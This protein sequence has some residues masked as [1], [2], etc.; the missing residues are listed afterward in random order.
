MEVQPIKRKKDNRLLYVIIAAA[1]VVLVIILVL[2][3]SKPKLSYEDYVELG[4]KYMSSMGYNKAIE[5]YSMA[6][7][8]NP[9][10]TEAVLGLAD[11]YCSKGDPQKALEVLN[12]ADASNAAVSEKINTITAEFI[13]AADDTPSD[14]E[15]PAQDVEMS[16]VP[17]I[18]GQS[19]SAAVAACEAVG[20]SY[21]I[22]YSDEGGT[23]TGAVISQSVT[24]GASVPTGSVLGFTVYDGSQAA[25]T[26]VAEV[27]E[28]VADGDNASENNTPEQT[29]AAQAVS[30]A[31]P[32]KP[33]TKPKTD[34]PVQTSASSSKKPEAKTVTIK[35]K[36]LSL[37]A[38][39]VDLS[40]TELT[41]YDLTGIA[42]FTS[43]KKL[44]ISGNLLSDLTPLKKLTGLTELDVSD[45]NIKDLSALG[46]LKKLS[47]LNIG[48]NQISSLDGITGLTGLTVLKASNNSI[49]SISAASEL[50][51]LSELDL[52]CNSITD[53][54][55]LTGLTKLTNLNL[56]ENNIDSISGLSGLKK[57]KKLNIW[58]ND[59]SSSDAEVKELKEALPKCQISC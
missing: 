56:S 45:N 42:K 9:D 48:H 8:L 33:S 5:N 25:E 14:E 21:E 59:V 24:A 11:A 19:E 34:K 16:V 44:D 39:S 58:G 35:G 50:T 1:A 7:E 4:N 28:E 15:A 36:K 49:E 38:T 3:L 29:Q 41:D 13:T 51:A 46:S 52:S 23:E 40:N 30:P 22:T 37:D 31:S 47:V 27:G 20:L 17:D 6:V 57:L 10:G 55:S 54:S 2:A 43:L 26:G 53:I 32:A 18:V 12:K